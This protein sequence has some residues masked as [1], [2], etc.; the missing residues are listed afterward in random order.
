MLIIHLRQYEI[1]VFLHWCVIR[2]VLSALG[3]KSGDNF[4]KTKHLT[5]E[6]FTSLPFFLV[7]SQHQHKIDKNALAENKSNFSYYLKFFF[8]THHG[9]GL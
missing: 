2:A 6:T 4:L 5:M 8:F 9:H 3:Y 7:P 1:V